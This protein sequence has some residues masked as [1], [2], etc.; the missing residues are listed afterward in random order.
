MNIDSIIFDLDG[1]MWDSIDV[2]VRAW[3]NVL[4]GNKEIRNA[5]TSK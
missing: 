2:V 3:N 1:T 5:I 4:Q